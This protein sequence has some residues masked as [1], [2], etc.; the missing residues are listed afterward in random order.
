MTIRTHSEPGGKVHN[1]DYVLSRR[2]PA[3]SSVYI[4]VLADGQ[5]GRSNGAE[6]AKAACESVWFEASALPRQRL[7]EDGTWLR[8]M[9]GADRSA[10]LTGG[11]TT[12]VALAIDRDFAAGASSGDS[13]AFFRLG[14]EHDV[15]E[16]TDRQRKNPPIGSESADAEP[17]MCHAIGGGRLLI[18]SDGLWKYCGYEALRSSFDLPIDSIVE[19]FRTSIL[20]RSGSALPDDLSLIVVDID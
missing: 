20:G 7:F 14:P 18:A 2:H 3:D 15:S 19:H 6:A 1:E 16:W 11:F 17:F 4:C 5:G 10:A 13:K 8:I 9:D 12:L